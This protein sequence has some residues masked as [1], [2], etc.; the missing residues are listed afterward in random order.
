MFWILYF[1]VEC[2]KKIAGH[3]APGLKRDIELKIKDLKVFGNS[4]EKPFQQQLRETHPKLDPLI[5][6]E[7]RKLCFVLN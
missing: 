2:M 3:E 4:G 1:D 6:K 5:P 7:S